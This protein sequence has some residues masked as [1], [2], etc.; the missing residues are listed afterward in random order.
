L[1]AESRFYLRFPIYDLPGV[2]GL[3]TTALG[4]H[5]ISITHASANL[6]G[7]KGN[8]G[9]V[10]IITHVT[11]EGRLRQALTETARLPV[12]TDAPIALRILE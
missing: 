6:V 5:Q 4:N 10:K 12:L 7:G 8:K 2:I 1:E 11:R 9:S 3:I